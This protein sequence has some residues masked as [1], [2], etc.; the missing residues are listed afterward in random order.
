MS[1]ISLE[2]TPELSRKRK[3]LLRRRG[4]TTASA[5]GAG[6]GIMTQDDH[7][8]N[9]GYRHGW[10]D[11]VL[12]GMKTPDRRSHVYTIGKTGSGKT[13]LLRNL[14]LQHIEAG[15]GVA[16]L[17]PHGDLADELLDHIPAR[18]TDDFIYFD[19]ANLDFPIGLNPLANIPPDSRHL[20][21][22]GMVSAFKSIW[23][24]SWGPRLEYILYNCIS[25]LLD[26]QNVTLLAV[27]RLLTDAHYRAWV[28]RQV[29]DP[30][31]RIFWTE[32]FA[33][34]DERFLR[35]AI[36]PIQNKIGALVTSGPIRNILG[37]VRNKLDFREIM[38]RR[39]IFIANLSKGR[40]GADKANLLGSL[41]TTQFQ[42]AAMSRADIPEEQREDFFLFIDEFH[43]FTTDAFASILS[44]IRK[45]RVNLVLSHQYI[46]QLAEP[47]RD[48]VFG[49]VGTLISF[50][51][52][53]SDS[54][55]LEKEFGNA[56]S[57]RQFVDL[58][59]FETIAKLL[60]DGVCGEP[61][62]GRTLPPLSN[63]ANQRDNL[64]R[65][66]RRRYGLARREVE[67]KITRWLR[68]RP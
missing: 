39:R 5:V 50:R 7:I 63:L 53:E 48:A 10:G 17:D 56:F 45:Y 61:F 58:S 24:D 44:E 25:S 51:V 37:Q 11:D 14:V 6:F 3:N 42:F 41:L 66:V 27:N 36:S 30:F 22:S 60:T 67:A 13:T 18:R 21:A 16:L 64:L 46:A 34:Y 43:N 20:I 19:P 9:F 28:L 1:G 4:L 38:D 35:D 47:I 32:E 26:C 65:V 33:N 29:R 57:S 59:K 2:S 55:V 62:Q 23:R 68:S 49:N 8:I 31:V 40:L 52:G 12:F 15:H 54:S